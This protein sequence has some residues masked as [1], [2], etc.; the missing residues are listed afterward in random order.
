M[1]L[2]DQEPTSPPLGREGSGVTLAPHLDRGFHRVQLHCPARDREGFQRHRSFPWMPGGLPLLSPSTPGSL[3]FGPNLP[4][5]R[6][7]LFTFT[8]KQ[9]PVQPLQPFRPHPPFSGLGR[10]LASPPL[11]TPALLV[12]LLL[13]STLPCCVPS[14][15]STLTPSGLAPIAPRYALA[16]SLRY[17]EG[18]LWPHASA[19]CHSDPVQFALSCT[20]LPP[21][22][23]LSVSVTS[24]A[25]LRD[26]LFSSACCNGP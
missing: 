4:T 25:P 20:H 16:I 10:P 17:L 24:P 18:I 1:L 11:V 14:L 26:P 13:R 3:N 21:L 15:H 5:A 2:D 23:C 7:Q 9:I 6:I 22:P 12:S 8:Q 19:Q